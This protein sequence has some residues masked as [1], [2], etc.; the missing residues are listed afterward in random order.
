M[1]RVELYVQTLRDR[2]KPESDRVH[3]S[4]YPPSP[5]RRETMEREGYAFFLVTFDLP[6]IVEEGIMVP[7]TV[8]E[9]ST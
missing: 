8:E 4:T 9:D 2:S 6:G 3:A 1:R 5:E 7:A